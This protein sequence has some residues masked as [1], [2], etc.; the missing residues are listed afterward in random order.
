VGE[1]RFKPEVEY[2]KIAP[3]NNVN[4]NTFINYVQK[5]EKMMSYSGSESSQA[6]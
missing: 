4:T 3:M 6:T 2:S 5:K 1:E